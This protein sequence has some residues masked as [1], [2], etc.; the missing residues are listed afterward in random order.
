VPHIGIGLRWPGH[1]VDGLQPSR[2][3]FPLGAATEFLI[4]PDGNGGRW[5]IL[6]DGGTRFA[7]KR[8]PEVSPLA[9]S[10]RF[11]LKAQVTTLGDGRSRYRVKQWNDGA[12]EPSA[13]AVESVEAA[14]EDLEAGSFLVVP[15]NTDVTVHELSVVPVD[16]APEA[17]ER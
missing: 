14:G 2:Q 16:P 12:P 9:P 6:A 13:W 10:R 17:G 3:W 8:A 1:T 5:R 11:W 15:H 7:Q 4:G